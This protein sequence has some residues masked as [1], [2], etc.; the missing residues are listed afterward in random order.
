MCAGKWFLPW[1]VPEE[2]PQTQLKEKA[3]N[4]SSWQ[5]MTETFGEVIAIVEDE[6]YYNHR[7]G[8]SSPYF[9]YGES[10]KDMCEERGSYWLLDAIASYQHKARSHPQMKSFQIWELKVDL[11]KHEA[12]LVGSWD[13][14]KVLYRQRIEYTDFPLNYIKLYLEGGVLMAAEER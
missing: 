7:I 14:D 11:A 9:I 8:N 5:N 13:T 6:Q 12:L 10:I 3:N 1:G 4:A 2:I